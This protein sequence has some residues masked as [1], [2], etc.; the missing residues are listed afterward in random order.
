MKGRNAG[1]TEVFRVIRI[2]SYSGIL[3]EIK[4]CYIFC[5]ENIINTIIIV[6]TSLIFPR[7]FANTH[8]CLKKYILVL[9]SRDPW[10]SRD[11]GVGLTL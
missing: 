7:C 8:V 6:F 11:V 5:P 4:F 1:F 3:K 10:I 2:S 9:K